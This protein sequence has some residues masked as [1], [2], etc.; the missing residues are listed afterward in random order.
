MLMERIDHKRNFLKAGALLLA[1]VIFTFLVK[2]V[3]VQPIGPEGTWVGFAAINVTIKNLLPLNMTWFKITDYLGYVLVLLSGIYA[4]AGV[5]QFF[6]TKSLRRVDMG[7]LVLYGLFAAA[8]IMYILFKFV[9]INYRPVL[10][11]GEL[12]ASFP[13]SH[14]VL[15]LCASIGIA[16]FNKAKFGEKTKH[17]NMVILA[18]GILV[19]LGRILSGVHWF[20]DIVGG[21]LY[22]SAF[23]AF[24]NAARK[25]LVTLW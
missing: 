23:I 12:E 24:Y 9:A 11:D 1:A 6:K 5:I 16:I 8:V 17:L 7:L 18:I 21:A 2:I 13:S 4:A 22:A 25:K 3:N 10:I 15:A 14:M 20:T 19:V